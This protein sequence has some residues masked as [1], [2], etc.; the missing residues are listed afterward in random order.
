MKV[1]LDLNGWRKEVEH[2][3]NYYDVIEAMID[4]PLNLTVRTPESAKPVNYNNPT[5]VRFV[6]S[7]V[8]DSGEYIYKLLQEPK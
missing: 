2:D 1:T 5:R 6:Y 3:G 8:E 4:Y 7:H